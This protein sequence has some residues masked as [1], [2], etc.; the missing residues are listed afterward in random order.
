MKADNQTR[1]KAVKVGDLVKVIRTI[2]TIFDND[3]IGKVGLIVSNSTIL[4]SGFNVLVN[5]RVISFYTTEIEKI[6]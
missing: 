4:P 3:C 6:K 1:H 5:E 2:G